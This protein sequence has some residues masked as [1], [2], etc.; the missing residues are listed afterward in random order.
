MPTQSRVVLKSVSR[1]MSVGS[2]YDESA[3]P[4]GFVCVNECSYEE[5]TLES[6]QWMRFK[7][8]DNHHTHV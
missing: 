2:A 5:Y 6:S 1:M 8:R 4:V 7:A 3:A